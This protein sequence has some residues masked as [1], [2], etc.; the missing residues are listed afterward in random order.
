MG[1]DPIRTYAQLCSS[2]SYDSHER[3]LIMD[4]EDTSWRS[5]FVRSLWPKPE[6]VTFGNRNASRSK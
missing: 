1:N 4:G 3:I 6:V 5:A 2:V